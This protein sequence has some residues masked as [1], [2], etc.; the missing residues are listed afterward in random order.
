MAVTCAILAPAGPQRSRLLGTLYKDERSQS[1]PNYSVLE[2]MY[3]ER[4]L[5]PAEV[6]AFASSLA[7]PSLAFPAKLAV[8]F[9]LTYHFLGACR[10]IAW[11]KTGK[12]FTNAQMLHSSY[13]LAGASAVLSL[14]LAM[15]TLPPK[16]SDK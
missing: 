16:K 2:K 8:G 4:L 15:T 12:G 14:G 6:E 1:L 10:H 13:A 7:S 5:R 3:M 9:P 11:D